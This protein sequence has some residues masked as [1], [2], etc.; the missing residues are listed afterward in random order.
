MEGGDTR[1]CV[2]V[3]SRAI[4]LDPRNAKLFRMRGHALFELS[5]YSSAIANYK[6]TVSLSPS[7]AET[8]AV[9]M[10][11]THSRLGEEL[12]SRGNHEAALAEFSSA[13]KLCPDTRNYVMKRCVCG[14]GLS[15]SLSLSLPLPLSIVWTVF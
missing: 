7:E 3:L 2:G 12:G 6:K 10:A 4:S 5:D 13:A 1:R 15:S 14:C 8:V 11:N 9:R